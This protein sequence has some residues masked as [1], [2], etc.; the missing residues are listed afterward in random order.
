MQLTLATVYDKEH[1]RRNEKQLERYEFVE[2]HRINVRF[3][4]RRSWRV[5]VK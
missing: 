3:S 1:E 4:C 2:A 5:Y